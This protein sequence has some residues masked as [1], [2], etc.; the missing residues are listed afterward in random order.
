M[1]LSI[2][3]TNEDFL[4]FLTERTTG[5][6]ISTSYRTLTDNK[7]FERFCNDFN[8][9][10][11][12]I[13]LDTQDLSKEFRKFINF[14][15]EG[16][17]Y[18]LNT[19]E[20]LI[21]T[22]KDASMSNTTDLEKSLLA[23]E[24]HMEKANQKL[25]IVRLDSLRFQDIYKS[26]T[27]GDN[28]LDAKPKKLIKYKVTHNSEGVTIQPKKTKQALVPDV[29]KGTGATA[30][31][32]DLQSAAL[33]EDTVVPSERLVEP[34]RLN[35]EFQ[36]DLAASIAD[37]TV[38]FI[39][40]HRYTGKTTLALKCAKELEEQNLKTTVLDLTARRDIRLINKDINC[41][42]SFIRGLDLNTYTGKP[43][44]GLEVFNKVYTATFLMHL[45]K[46]IV[47]TSSIVFCE[48]DLD[49]V[50]N[51]YK[52]FRG[53]KVVLMP[54][55]NQLTVVRDS[56]NSANKMSIPIVPIANNVNKYGDDLNEPNLKDSIG[57]ARAIFNFED[58]LSLVSALLR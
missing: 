15:N 41:D 22:F 58:T 8:H 31:L 36:D 48:V 32:E 29:P 27:A 57:E 49:Q 6:K 40:G 16:K 25:R 43:V 10:N 38:V 1:K 11:S 4:S 35:K 37:A 39:T 53:N 24:A 17:S 30:K 2:I 18:F 19:E 23:I 34:I 47:T 51:I 33:L 45:L 14:L 54:V 28:I 44:L 9:V 13:F 3:T 26:L 46:G 20:I 52:S 5:M 21:I 7:E 12:L 42:L 56:I 55:T 50:E